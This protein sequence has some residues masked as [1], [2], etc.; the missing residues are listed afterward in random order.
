VIGDASADHKPRS[1]VVV[2]VDGTVVG[3]S[4]VVVVGA[5]VVDVVVVDGVTGAVVV[6]AT[7]CV[8]VVV[9]AR[10]VVVGARVA[11]VV[12]DVGNKAEPGSVETFDD[13]ALGGAEGPSARRGEPVVVLVVVG[14]AA[15][16]AVVVVLVATVVGG[17][18]ADVSPTLW[19]C[20]LN[21][22][23]SW[24]T[25]TNNAATARTIAVAQLHCS[26]RR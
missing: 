15:G 11:G 25:I 8:V 3:G 13:L 10:V 14:P 23:S 1:D 9:G 4:D 26:N 7:G 22:W 24:C 6:V 21:G 16:L 17:N 19:P 2:V 12:V 5:V 18:R 20:T